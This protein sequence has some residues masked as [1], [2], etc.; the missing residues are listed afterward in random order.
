MDPLIYYVLHV[1]AA[2][3]LTGVTFAACAAPL[4]EKR[5]GVMILGGIATLVMVI[6]GFGLAAKLHYGFPGWLIAKILCW[7]VLSALGGMAFRKPE[8]ARTLSI[9]ALVVIAVAVYCVYYKP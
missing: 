4:P 1:V 6:A 7:L 8:S 3:A 9:I 2:F 5:R